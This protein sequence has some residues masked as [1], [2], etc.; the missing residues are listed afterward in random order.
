MSKPRLTWKDVVRDA[1][2]ELGGQG[3]LSE[4]NNIVEGNPKAKTKI[5]NNPTW[6]ATI[7]RVVRQYKIFG[8]LGKGVYKLLE[9]VPI[10][11]EPQEFTEEP[12]IDHGI[13]QGMLVTLGKI[14]G[15]E[16]YAPP[17]DQ[18]IRIFQD[19]PLRDFVTVSDCTGIFKGPNLRKIREI[20][21]LW[22][23]EDDYGLF[24]V[25][26]FEVEETTRVKSG[27]DRLLK[28]PTRFRTRFFVIGPS[29]KEKI[30]FDQY[31]NQTPFRDFKDKF[32]FKLYKELEEL[33][34]SALIHNDRRKQFRIIERRR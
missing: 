29:T 6:Q 21:T 33:Y 2:L 5:T 23:D 4:V 13:A 9:E 24:P 12:E 22:F 11:T 16:T 17:H 25:Y 19:K 30:L 8:P 31:I 1:L 34:N 28:I 15:Y 20:D 7:R 27:L 18:T 32:L 26:A 14:Y 3:H 10:K